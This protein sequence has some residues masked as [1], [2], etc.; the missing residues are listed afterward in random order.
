MHAQFLFQ[1]RRRF[2]VGDPW[3]PRESIFLNLK[4]KSILPSELVTEFKKNLTQSDILHPRLLKTIQII[5]LN[6]LKR[7]RFC[8]GGMRGLPTNLSSLSLITYAPTCH[9][10]PHA[11]GWPSQANPRPTAAGQPEASLCR[12]AA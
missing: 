5:P 6:S 2:G 12:S 10:L 11:K 8:C 9:H 4:V 7:F 3:V 1:R